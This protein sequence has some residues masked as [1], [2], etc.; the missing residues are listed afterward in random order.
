M[1]IFMEGAFNCFIF[2][3]IIYCDEHIECG[4]SSGADLGNYGWGGR[5]CVN[6]GKAL[7]RGTKCRAGGGHG[8]GVSP[9]PIWKKIKIRDCLDAF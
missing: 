8:R 1:A 2:F 4:C 3:H 7:D 5:V 6:K 9:L